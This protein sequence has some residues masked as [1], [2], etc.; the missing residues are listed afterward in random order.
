MCEFLQ[1]DNDE[2][3]VSFDE[4]RWFPAL[5]EYDPGITTEKW[6]ELL[7]NDSII[8]DDYVWAKVLAVFYAE[9]ENAVP[10]VLNKKYGYNGT[11]LQYCTNIARC[12][13]NLTDCPVYKNKNTMGNIC[14]FF[15]SFWTVLY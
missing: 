3:V 8:G 10:S 15:S 7:K 1:P 2:Q 6:L 4:I 13:R 11:L 9:N 5:D 12:I 14:I